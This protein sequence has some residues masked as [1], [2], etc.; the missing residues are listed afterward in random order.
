MRKARRLSREEAQLWAQVART[1]QPL[2][3]RLA[4]RVEEQPL[5]AEV[6]PPVPGPTPKPR[7]AKVAPSSPPLAEPAQPPRRLDRNGLDA[8][9]DKKLARAALHPD[10]TL[11][12]H[13]HGLD[14]AYTR[15][16]HGIAQA[17]ALGARLMLVITGRPRPVEA[18]DRGG[19]RGAIRAKLLDWL[20]HSRHA[21]SIAAVRAAH[22]RHGGEGAV[23]VVLRRR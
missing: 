16:D 13:G 23:Y 8:S 6:A 19:S 11:D 7:P 20:A 14:A 17:I 22:R 18:A 10:F 2:R 5:A 1:V 3:Q 21:G 9:W 12:L 4:A 15:L